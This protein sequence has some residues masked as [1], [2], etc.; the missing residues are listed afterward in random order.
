M[1]W[2]GGERSW[3]NMVQKRFERPGRRGGRN[4]ERETTI[5]RAE[6]E[7]GKSVEHGAAE[8][9]QGD[10]CRRGPFALLLQR[11]LKTR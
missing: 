4:K 5:D 6:R 1:G 7:R 10:N 2:H 3:R 9:G 8:R 11:S